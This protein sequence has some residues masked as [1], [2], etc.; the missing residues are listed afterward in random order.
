[1]EIIDPL[2]LVVQQELAELV[3]L[4]VN[5]KKKRHDVISLRACDKR[6]GRSKNSTGCAPEFGYSWLYEKSCGRRSFS[7]IN[8]YE[9]KRRYWELLAVEPAHNTQHLR[10]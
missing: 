5:S 10:S 3:A 1:M 4:V 7:T 2:Q 8:Q 9:S 6:D